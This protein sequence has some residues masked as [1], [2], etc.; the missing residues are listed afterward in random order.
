MST[1][2]FKNIFGAPR[3]GAHSLRFMDIAVVD[4]VMTVVAAFAIARATNKP[5]WL[6]F[7]ILFIIGEILHVVMCVDT[8]FVRLLKTHSSVE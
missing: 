1:C 4:T 2:P 8:T 5:F 3:T 7:L 6:V